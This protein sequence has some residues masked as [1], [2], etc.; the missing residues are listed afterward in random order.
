MTARVHQ[1][2]RSAGGVPK[3]AVDRVRISA[4]GLEGDWQ[5]DRV[6][7]GGPDRAVCLFPLELIETLQADG[8]PI[9]PGAVGENATTSGVAWDRMVPGT[10]VRIG[11][12]VELEIVSYTAPCKTIRAAFADED[13]TRISQKV[14][15]GESRVYARVLRDGEV[16]VG[17]AITVHVAG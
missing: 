2:S 16:A 7:H 11:G 6:H 5:H 9:V 3:R 12:E 8:H 1:L 15:P 17:D 13:F 14:H 10:R 4:L